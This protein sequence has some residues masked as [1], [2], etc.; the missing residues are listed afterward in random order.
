MASEVP[1]LLRTS[2]H[3]V[4]AKDPVEW[5]HHTNFI[6]QIPCTECP[7]KYI[8]QTARQLAVRI[9]EHKRR[10]RFPPRSP[11]E[12]KK[13]V[14]DSTIALH[15]LES[16]HQISFDGTRI[17]QSGFKSHVE[18]TCAEALQTNT[19]SSCINRSDG[20]ENGLTVHLS[21]GSNQV[22]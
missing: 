10:T 14:R 17:V 6:Y 5:K 9:A 13:L 7:A 21:K 20:A 15:A 16:N 1:T 22:K 3:L 18:R 12:L 8:N 11:I 4:K 2:W 19:Q